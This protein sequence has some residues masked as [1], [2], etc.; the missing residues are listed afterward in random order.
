MQFPR[1]KKA[2]NVDNP[3]VFGI[4]SENHPGPSEEEFWA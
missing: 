3:G 4:K 2:K 1:K